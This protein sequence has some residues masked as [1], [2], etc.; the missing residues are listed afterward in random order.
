[1]LQEYQ[2]VSNG[3]IRYRFIDVD[4]DPQSKEEALRQGIAPVEFNVISKEHF[5]VRQGFMGMVLQH[6][7]RKEVLPIIVQTESI[8]YDLTSRIMQIARERKRGIGFVSSHGA[9]GPESLHP[10]IREMLERNYELLPVDLRALSKGAGIAADVDALFVLGPAEIFSEKDLLPLDQFLMSDR[11]IVLAI[12]PRKADMK[13]FVATPLTSG[14]EKWLAHFGIS[15]S[16]NYVLDAQNQRVQ[17]S[18]QRGWVRFM[19]LVEYPL[20]IVSNDLND[21]HPVTRHLKG[22]TL[23]LSGEIRISSS[24]AGRFSEL[25]RSSP[26]SWQSAAWSRGVVHSISPLQK[27]SMAKEDKKGPFILAAA[28]TGPFSSYFAK[29]KEHA[30]ELSLK[31]GTGARM[32]ILASSKFAH[33]EMA[34]DDS[35]PGLLLN[36]ADWLGLDDDLISIRS[37]GIIFRPLKEVRPETKR[38]VRWTNILGPSILVLCFGLGRWRLRQSRRQGRITRF[39]PPSVPADAT[40]DA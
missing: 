4:T 31:S 32:I 25:I 34:V 33:P 16:K 5:E 18:Q 39:S 21:T 20:F 14:L 24:A 35:G 11:P 8:E 37:K 9:M 13:S 1:L 26:K 15:L 27:I 40:K 19:N 10:R 22:I 29:E 17:V 7:D 36:L 23:P 38:M 30:S 28:G 3:K 12:D 2:E 6:E